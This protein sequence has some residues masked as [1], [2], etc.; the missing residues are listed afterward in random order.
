MTPEI[1]HY[2]LIKNRKLIFQEPELYNKVVEALEGKEFCLTLKKRHKQISQNKHAYYRGG[3]LGVLYQTEM[4]SHLDNKDQIHDLYFAP[5]FLTYT[6]M[7]NING[8]QKEVRAVRS[9]ADLSDEE[10]GLF[11][12]RVI[13]DC[14]SELGIAIS[15]PETYYSKYYNKP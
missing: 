2:G 12:E 5:K 10:M 14:E 13:A 9:L 3:I 11:I 4:F 7:L 8:Q 6:K 15:D 1:R